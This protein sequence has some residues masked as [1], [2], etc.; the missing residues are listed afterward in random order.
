[1]RFKSLAELFEDM[2]RHVVRT[3]DF[4]VP[5]DDPS[6][7]PPLLGWSAVRLDQDGNVTDPAEPRHWSISLQD[8]GRA[9]SPG[10]SLSSFAR[11]S[12]RRGV[13]QAILDRHC[14]RCHLYV[15]P[16]KE[17]PDGECAVREVMAG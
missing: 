15:G 14:R 4:V 3:G 8:A 9:D 16:G 17:H 5:A 13:T 7:S 6:A 11:A 2:H 10:F 1:M 12:D